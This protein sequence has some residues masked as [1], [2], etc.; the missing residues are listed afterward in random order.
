M[1]RLIFSVLFVAMAIVANAFVNKYNIVSK[2]ENNVE[3][4]CSGTISLTGDK[5]R[6]GLISYSNLTIYINDMVNYEWSLHYKNILDDTT[7]EMTDIIKSYKL[8]MQQID[9]ST[10]VFVLPQFYGNKQG[11]ISYKA[12]QERHEARS[13]A[14]V[15]P[16]YVTA[17]KAAEEAA[18]A[19]K[20]EDDAKKAQ[21][22]NAMKN[23][24]GSGS[25]TGSGSGRSNGAS[26]SLAGRGL[27]GTLTKPS[28]GSNAE[29]TVVVA[30]RVNQNGNVISATKGA[31]TNTNDQSLIN[32]AIEA[33]K[34]A[35]FT[36]GDGVAVGSI[37]YVFKLS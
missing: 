37:T 34:K 27:N 6:E 30:I 10:F 26:W 33:A 29:G 16:A 32:A 31:G 7:V 35:K 17:R 25:G 9:D 20:A 15:D 8:T 24:F 36:P 3:K 21:A 5:N 12:V 22:Q 1:R 11:T 14:I 28:Y 2:I 19:T 13:E 4:P 18:K 23:L